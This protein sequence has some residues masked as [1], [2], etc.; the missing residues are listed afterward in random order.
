MIGNDSDNATTAA[1]ASGSFFMASSSVGLH[2]AECKLVGEHAA[3]SG[4]KVPRVGGVAKKLPFS[5]Q[6]EARLLEFGQDDRFVDPMQRLA[7]ADAR[8][9]LRRAIDHAEMPARL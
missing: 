4:R 5:L 1:S 8:A 6:H 3:V 2:E 7:D 9:G